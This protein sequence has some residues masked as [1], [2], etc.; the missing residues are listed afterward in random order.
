M[1]MAVK[2][3]AYINSDMLK[4]ARSVS[5]PFAPSIDLVV[6]QL[7]KLSYKKIDAWE[8]GSDFPTINEAKSLA[9]LYKV[10][11][12]CFY[13]SKLPEM[14][15]VRYN[16]RR[17]LNGS[18]SNLLSYELWKEIQ[19]ITSNRD[20]A[21][22]CFPDIDTVFDP[23]PKL[24]KTA[25]VKTIAQNLREYIDITS[26]F[27]SKNE[28]NQNDPFKFFQKLIE[29]KGIIVA[30][31]QK[32]AVSDIRGFSIYDDVLPIIAVTSKDSKRA[33]VFTLFHELAHLIRRSSSL[34]LVD[35]GEN[36][37]EEEKICNMIA[38]ETLLPEDSFR[39]VSLSI[40]QDYGEW[41]D[42]CLTDISDKFAV[43]SFVVL[44]RIHDLNLMKG[45][46]YY[47]KYSEMIHEYNSYKMP[48]QKSVPIPQAYLCIGRNGTLYP[49][50]LL[51]AYDKGNITYGTL[52]QALDLNSQHISTLEQVLFK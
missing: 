51:S 25:D 13:Y 41:N 2:N 45:N 3:L 31:I 40:Y 30:Q 9:K 34:C 47:S 15:P 48:D 22:E 50:V 43:S 36:S 18:Q 49:K 20:V 21:I 35:F 28:Y 52:C 7:P 24:D 32:V 39:E 38:A 26:P 16:D 37:D 33:K 19:R 11:F 29:A 6:E 17:T 23:L 42:Q 4:W 27:N 44:R 12:A 46:E 5:S 1:K 8:N 10:P 14:T